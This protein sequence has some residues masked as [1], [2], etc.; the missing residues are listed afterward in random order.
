MDGMIQF[1]G[2]IGGL[3]FLAT[4]AV[5]LL[6]LLINGGLFFLDRH[7]KFAGSSWRRS[8]LFST[9]VLLVFDGLFYLSVL[10][11]QQVWT[12]DEGKAFD[13]Q[14]FFIWIPCHVVGYL[15]LLLIARKGLLL[16]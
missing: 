8:F 4:V 11:P 6:S 16:K 5:L 10:R 13:N 7:N 14:K 2:L 3:I 1:N 12:Q 15:L 9:I